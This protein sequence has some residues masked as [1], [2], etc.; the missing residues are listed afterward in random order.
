[1]E[2][3]NL[4]E[5]KQIISLAKENGVKGQVGHVE[6]FNPAYLHV[7]DKI[8]TPMFIETHRLAQ[9]NPRGTDVPV[10]LDLMIH[11]IDIILDI[12]K[13]DIKNI[14]SSG[15]SI[16]SKS[17]D[18]ANAR[19]EFVNG[20]VANLTA[21]RIS[22]KNMRKIRI[23]QKENYI[24]IDFFK[25]D[26]E[27]VIMKDY[28]G[29]EST[30]ELILENAEGIKKQITIDKNRINNSNA[31]LEELESLADSIEKDIPPKVTLEDGYKALKVALEI[32]TS[33]NK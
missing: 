19:I 6:R 21:S 17:P 11:D 30:N 10:I 24:S 8:N 23:F 12:V 29:E 26:C 9:F 5:A 22:L 2:H 4:N 13:S 25:K 1:M 18:I 14:S 7:K 33:F 31:I 28:S 32:I 20:C 15:I 27:V 16:I 3:S